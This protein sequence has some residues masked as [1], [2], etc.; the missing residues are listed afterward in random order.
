MEANEVLRTLR[1]SRGLTQEA[2]AQRLHVTRQAISRWE[3][4]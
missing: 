4:G 3:T 2:L 1:E